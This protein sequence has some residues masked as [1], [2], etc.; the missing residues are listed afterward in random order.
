ME[1]SED[2]NTLLKAICHEF[3]E[4]NLEFCLAGGWAA[5]ILGTARTTIDIDIIITMKETRKD[6]IVSIL[7]DSFQ[8]IQSHDSEMK[9]K[10]ISIWRNIL[11]L[12]G[13]NNPFVLD[14]IIADSEY[15]ENI[16]KNSV[17]IDYEDTVIPVVSVEDLIILKLISFR[18]QDQLDIE[19]LLNS[20][21]SL[22]WNYLD[23]KISQFNLDKDYIQGLK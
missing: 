3:K 12:R 7:E 14:L 21:H 20:G 17:E 6:F 15:L 19:N 5:S 8:L 4:H 16:V 1:F 18:K 2:L 9:F 23:E 22:D 10:N 11:S 13:K